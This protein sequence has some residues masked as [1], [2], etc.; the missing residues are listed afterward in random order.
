MAAGPVYPDEVNALRSKLGCVGCLAKTVGYLV[1]IGILGSIL[2]IG[3]E[4]VFAPWSFYMGG[5]FHPIPMWRGWGQVKSAAGREYALYV[6]FE[7]YTPS[8]R[9]GSMSSGGPEVA[10]WGELC[11]PHG[12]NY[13]VRVTGYLQRNMGSSTDGKKMELDVYRRPWY[14]SFAGRWDERPRLIFH[15]A[16]RNPDLVLYDRGSLDRA[17]NPDGTLRP[18]N[19]GVW[20]SGEQGQE[21]V[22][23]EGDK[24]GYQAACREVQGR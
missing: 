8:G 23:H 21:L 13:K 16:W 5:R 24:T 3:I 1:L 12:E 11:S 18:A 22:L 9:G 19:S 2:L 15:G 14:W 7:P 6:W 4:A 17:F 10:G 20:K